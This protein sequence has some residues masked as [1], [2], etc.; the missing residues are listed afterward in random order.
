MLPCLRVNINAL[1]SDDDDDTEEKT[2][3]V[4]WGYEDAAK[5]AA[6]GYRDIV[7]GLYDNAG[8]D[9]RNDEEA[10][11]AVAASGDV[12]LVRWLLHVQRRTITPRKGMH[13]A[14]AN[15]HVNMLELLTEEGY[16]EDNR[17]GLLAKASG[18]SWPD[19][20]CVLDH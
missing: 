6:A 17:V 15:G 10:L 5:A 20:C 14:A 18:N 13:E 3:F 19:G 12:T 7:M 4:D 1:E 8:S 11:K 2:L 9:I 16:L